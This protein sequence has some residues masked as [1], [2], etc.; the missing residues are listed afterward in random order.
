MEPDS[1]YL[2]NQNKEVTLRK[3]HGINHRAAGITHRQ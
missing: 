2:E 3:M 1:D